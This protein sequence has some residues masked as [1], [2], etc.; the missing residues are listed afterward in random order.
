[1]GH[2][3]LFLFKKKKFKTFLSKNHQVVQT[4]LE[5]RLQIEEGS[6]Q[7][8]Q[9]M[10]EPLEPLKLLMLQVHL[11]ISDSCHSL[12]RVGLLPLSGNMLC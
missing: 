12:G 2:L 10:A 5:S 3:F 8:G 1:M 4:Q 7:H 11:Q 6:G 9:K